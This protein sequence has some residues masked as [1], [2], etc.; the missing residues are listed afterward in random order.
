MKEYKLVINNLKS[1]E[2][3][4]TCSI[5][6]DE[7]SLKFLF[8]DTVIS[9]IKLEN[10]LNVSFDIE[11]TKILFIKRN[12][13]KITE[14]EHIHKFVILD[15]NVSY[16]ESKINGFKTDIKE[17]WINEFNTTKS[18][19]IEGIIKKYQNDSIIVQEKIDK[20]KILIEKTE[21][22]YDKSLN[23][24]I[25]E[26]NTFISSL[27]DS[28]EIV[29]KGEKDKADY[30]KFRAECLE[31]LHE[32]E[33][34]SD[35]IKKALAKSIA[36][37]KTIDFLDLYGLEANKSAFISIY[38]SHVNSIEAMRKRIKIEKDAEEFDLYIKE[39]I[40]SITLLD[41][42]SNDIKSMIE[43]NKSEIKATK[44]NKKKTLEQNKQKI[45]SLISKL[46]ETI[47]NQIKLEEIEKKEKEFNNYLTSAYNKFKEKNKTLIGSAR[48]AFLKACEI[49]DKFEFNSNKELE[50]NFK[51]VDDTLEKWQKTI[52]TA[53]ENDT[54]E[55]EKLKSMSDD[56]KEN[57]EL[58]KSKS[59]TIYNNFLLNPYFIL[60]I[61]IKATQSE[62]MFVRDK[63]EKYN[64]LKITKALTSEF[65]LRN[66]DKPIRD[67]STVQ[68]AISSLKDTTQKFFW[69]S[70]NEYCEIWESILIFD[71]I[72]G[73]KYNLDLMLACYFHLL[74]KDI[75]FTLEEER[76][77]FICALNDFY[78]LSN[79]EISTKLV[80]Q[81]R[82]SE[83][84]KSNDIAERFKTLYVE[85]L[86]TCLEY[87]DLTELKKFLQT[88]DILD[89]GDPLLDYFTERLIQK[90][91]KI[92]IKM[93]NIN[94]DEA[95]DT[96]NGY[97]F[98]GNFEIVNTIKKFVFANY[99][100]TYIFTKR[101]ENIF[102]QA[103]S[104]C[105]I[106]LKDNSQEKEALKLAKEIYKD[107]NSD[108]KKDLRETFGYK[109]LGASESDLTAR[110]M[111]N[112]GAD[113]YE[114]KGVR[115]NIYTAF[116]WY[117][118]AADA[119]YSKSMLAVALFYLRGEGCSASKTMAK[120]YLQKA[121]DAGES[122][123]IPVLKNLK[124]IPHE[125]YDLGY[126]YIGFR[127]TKYVEVELSYIGY[128]RLLSD[129][130]YTQYING[131][132]YDY[133]GGRQTQNPCCR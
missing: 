92:Q 79:E 49:L 34:D 119:G 50:A 66:I 36:I 64:K 78:K 110:E 58:I 3:K 75:A 48:T 30:Y 118:R 86:L 116:S 13:L 24:N 107:S 71:W 41:T 62:A 100:E 56:S 59:K 84:D 104:N 124:E 105:I 38:N 23:K 90:S 27:A 60:G 8:K 72:K 114:G 101:I 11:T 53:T 83:D 37:L 95:E 44:F 97:D 109:K 133:Y 35:E 112:I 51:D 76:K 25:D 93:A 47:E 69:F 85:P 111:H 21:F 19:R 102:N 31:K 128:V 42:Y 132:D 121:I 17:K 16:I 12:I 80:E 120:Y 81:N 130:Q 67:L 61:S 103:A 73:D 29:S 74:V 129:Y 70:S 26:L 131:E 88:I 2:L 99:K 43:K 39:K 122:D 89:S 77:I 10:V 52:A 108:M 127:E 63:V 54:N 33:G 32:K 57:M 65:D 46:N 18:N 94:D 82:C 91:D 125:D 1:A 40:G 4:I 20:Y 5:S 9:S 96:A 6:I 126:V 68:T 28:I 106:A 7:N 87:L 98:I 55:I 117:K 15:N 22:N 45:D 123:A 14:N 113:Y 115:K